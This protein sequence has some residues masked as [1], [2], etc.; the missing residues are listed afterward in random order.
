M[1]QLE[2]EKLSL[3]RTSGVDR[4]AAGRLAAL[5]GQLQ[6]LKSEQSDL[7][8]RWEKERTDMQRIS[9]LKVPPL[10]PLPHL[11]H[12]RRRKFFFLLHFF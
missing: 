9:S 1:L 6:A 8:K 12:A 5:E 2:M 3:S 10:S 4:V 11:S 7:T